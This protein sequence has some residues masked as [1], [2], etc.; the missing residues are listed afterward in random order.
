MQSNWNAE[1][2]FHQLLEENKLAQKY[3][4]KFC[5]VADL[6]G[7]EDALKNLQSAQAIMAV[8]E[9]ADGF[10]ELNNTPRTRRV[11]TVFLAMRHKFDDKKARNEKLE[12]MRELFRQLMSKLFLEKTRLELNFIYLDPRIAFSEINSYFFNG[13]A[14]AY[15]QLA[16]DI[17]TDLR[18]NP[19]EWNDEENT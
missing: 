3:N 16:T 8:S 4:F 11:K 15:F 6:E 19:N 10:T 2:F 14:C 12:I 5:I 18:Y 13:A 7:F 9:S 17:Y 1:Q